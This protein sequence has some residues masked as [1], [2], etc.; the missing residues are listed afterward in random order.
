MI[1]EN[2]HVISYPEV[3]GAAREARLP[4]FDPDLPL[5]VE[6]DRTCFAM[7]G[8]PPGCGRVLLAAGGVQLVH[9][10]SGRVVRSTLKQLDVVE[11]D[12]RIQ[13][14]HILPR[15]VDL[16]PLVDQHIMVRVEHLFRGEEAA[17]DGRIRSAAGE[18]LVWGRDGA[19]PKPA[20]AV[21]GLHLHLVYR[22]GR[23]A[24]ACTTGSG[25]V[26]VDV[27][28]VRPVR[29]AGVTYSLACLRAARFDASFVLI[30]A[31]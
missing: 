4:R 16:S 19:F 14:K 31:G 3:V 26:E 15:R 1:A 11:D 28:S 18:L 20:T 2:L 27:G 10:V 21:D 23:S 6:D 8:G 30:Q 9:V 12:A 13:I 24:L 25:V 29:H 22:R 7:T 17:V 5:A